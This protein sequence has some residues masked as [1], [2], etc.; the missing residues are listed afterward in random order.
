MHT[1]FLTH[2]GIFVLICLALFPRL[3]LLIASFVTGGW[4]WWPGLVFTPRL[5]VAFL[6]LPYWHTNPVLVV[7][8]WS[9]AVGAGHPRSEIKLAF[10]WMKIWGKLVQGLVA[11]GWRR[12]VGRKIFSESP[13]RD[14]GS[15][16]SYWGT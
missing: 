10:G 11:V 7:I 14:T 16:I 2:H 9:L 5:L 4:L 1:Q 3:T 8:A 13:R 6:A 12:I 15:L